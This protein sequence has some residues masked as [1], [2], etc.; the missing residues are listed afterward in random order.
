ME[1]KMSIHEI[2]KAFH[3][4]FPSWEISRE[5][6]WDTDGEIAYI[7]AR[8]VTLAYTHH[9]KWILKSSISDYANHIGAIISILER[10][11]GE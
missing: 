8:G 2:K 9:G 10:W 5:L 3:N 1:S 6:G 4:V 11:D 7:N